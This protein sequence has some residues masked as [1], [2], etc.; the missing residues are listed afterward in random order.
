MGNMDLYTKINVKIVC[1]FRI[2][3]TKTVEKPPISPARVA[4]LVIVYYNQF[5]TLSWSY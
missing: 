1:E 5:Q 2:Y 4:K 3:F